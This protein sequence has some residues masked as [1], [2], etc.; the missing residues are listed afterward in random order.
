MPK[1]CAILQLVS[2]PLNPEHS[3]IS[4]VTHKCMC[5]QSSY[6]AVLPGMTQLGHSQD[7]EYTKA[8]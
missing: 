6:L 3:Q 1:L 4:R 5:K 7:S 8:T 2:A